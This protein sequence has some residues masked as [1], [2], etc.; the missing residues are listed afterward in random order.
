VKHDVNGLLAAV[1]DADAYAAALATVVLDD[2]LRARLARS[3]RESA[4]QSFSDDLQAQR[5]IELYGDLLERRQ[6]A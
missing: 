2:E 6:A 4:E 1:G 3:A 5:F